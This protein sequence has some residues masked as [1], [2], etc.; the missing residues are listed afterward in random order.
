[1]RARPRQEKSV[2][3]PTLANTTEVSLLSFRQ[4]TSYWSHY[5]VWMSGDGGWGYDDMSERGGNK[6]TLEVPLFD[7]PAR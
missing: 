4:H 6:K 5:L 3:T 7:R 1:M 2:N